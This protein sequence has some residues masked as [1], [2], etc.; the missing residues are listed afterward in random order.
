MFTLT[1]PTNAV[2]RTCVMSV[3]ALTLAA[4]LSLAGVLAEAQAATQSECITEF[5]E[6]DASSTC[7]LSAAT[8]S[9]DNCTLTGLCSS[10]G[11]WHNTS[12]TTDID[13]VDDLQNCSGS[14]ATSC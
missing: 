13:N 1:S 4:A 7:E 10:G 12:I 8:A 5:S 14:L 2:R 3:A 6:S 11:S 9:G